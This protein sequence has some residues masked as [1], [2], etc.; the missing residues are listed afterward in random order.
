MS[1]R[2]ALIL[3]FAVGIAFLT[4]AVYALASGRVYGRTWEK[5]MGGWV[6]RSENPGYYWAYLFM[7]AVGGALIVFGCSV[8]GL[9]SI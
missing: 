6:H 8:I 7:Y 1:T 5:Y 2:T 9:F 4:M 3:A